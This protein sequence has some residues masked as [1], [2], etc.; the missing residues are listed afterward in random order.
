[1]F[2]A[3][4]VYYAVLMLS[5]LKE[6]LQKTNIWKLQI[7]VIWVF[8]VAC[9]FGLWYIF[10]AP[11]AQ[12][13]ILETPNL[14]ESTN[15]SPCSIIAIWDSIT[16]GYDLDLADSYPAQLENI[17]RSNGYNCRVVNGGISGNTSRVLLERLDFTLD[18]NKYDLAILTIGGNDGLQLLPIEPLKNNIADIIKKLQAKNILPVLAGMQIPNNAGAYAMEFRNIYPELAKEHQVP[19]YPFFLDW[20]AMNA[21]LN[22]PDGIHPNAEWY[23]IIAEKLYEFLLAEWIL[24]NFPKNR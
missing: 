18:E 9:A 11:N 2:E 21:N 20:V 7:F 22:L 3:S 12:N 23:R 1:M 10:P 8:T 6:I 13:A 19:F 4:Q 16:A 17:L 24:R 14:K 15:P 5:M